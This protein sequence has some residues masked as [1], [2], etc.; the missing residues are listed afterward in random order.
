MSLRSWLSQHLY[1]Q[2]SSAWGLNEEQSYKEGDRGI[3]LS[4]P[5]FFYLLTTLYDPPPRCPT[6]L[7]SRQRRAAFFTYLLSVLGVLKGKFV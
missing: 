2:I 6:T 1:S 3:A 7:E 4:I 5:T